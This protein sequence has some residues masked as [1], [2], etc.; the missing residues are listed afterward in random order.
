[1]VYSCAG[2]VFILEYYF[3]LKLFAAVHEAFNIVYSEKEEPNKTTIHQL[4]TKLWDTG[5][6]CL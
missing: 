4:V 3:A 6:V 1:M 5:S 2:H